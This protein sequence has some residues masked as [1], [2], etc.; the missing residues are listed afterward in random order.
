MNIL[1]ALIIFPSISAQAC[2]V[3]FSISSRRA[4]FDA[5]DFAAA[6][7]RCEDVMVNWMEKRPAVADKLEEEIA[8]CL[9]CF[10]YPPSHRRKIRTTNCLERLNQEVKRRTKVARIFPNE[11][12]CLR[13]VSALCCEQSEEWETGRQY[14]DA[15]LLE[16]WEDEMGQ[17]EETV[18]LMLSRRQAAAEIKPA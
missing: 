6:C 11:A 5:P 13:L 18:L 12:S 14:L 2:S 3:R 7:R 8:D 9:A 1:R 4:I 17:G 16:G 10:A 15:S